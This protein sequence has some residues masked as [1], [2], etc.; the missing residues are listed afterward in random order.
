MYTIHTL[1]MILF[2]YFFTVRGKNKTKDLVYRMREKTL[3]VFN[4]NFPVRD[5]VYP[6]NVL[7]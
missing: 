4:N 1:K 5:A 6:K 3:M 7:T 2:E